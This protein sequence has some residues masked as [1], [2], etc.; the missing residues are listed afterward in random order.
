[1]VIDFKYSLWRSVQSVGWINMIQTKGVFLLKRVILENWK[2][3]CFDMKDPIQ[4]K[5]ALTRPA[6]DTRLGICVCYTSQQVV[7]CFVLFLIP[8][9]SAVLITNKPKMQPQLRSFLDTCSGV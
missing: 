6:E 1:M 7:L 3:Q 9:K 5:Q 2:C 4:F 8:G